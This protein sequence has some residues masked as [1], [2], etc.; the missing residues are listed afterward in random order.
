[1]ASL[2]HSCKVLVDFGS[3]G[4]ACISLLLYHAF[5]DPAFLEQGK[6]VPVDLCQ[7]YTGIFFY[8]RG[9]K[10]YKEH[11]HALVYLVLDVMLFTYA[12]RTV[13]KHNGTFFDEIGSFY[14]LLLC[15]LSYQGCRCF[16]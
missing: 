3:L 10:H 16:L 12:L 11:S 1:M 2:M 5:M 8:C 4:F 15:I 9:L 7:D 14:R 13:H 6:Q